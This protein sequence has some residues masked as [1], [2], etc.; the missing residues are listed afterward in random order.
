MG[1][2]VKREGAYEELVSPV[3]EMEG[4]KVVDKEEQS[5]GGEKQQGMQCVTGE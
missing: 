1:R 2:K 3:M 4:K 5:S